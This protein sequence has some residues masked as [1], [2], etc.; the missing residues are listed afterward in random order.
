[1]TVQLSAATPT[2]RARMPNARVHTVSAFTTTAQPTLTVGG[3]RL[4]TSVTHGEREGTRTTGR[5]ARLYY[6][7]S[8]VSNSRLVGEGSVHASDAHHCLG[9]RRNVWRSL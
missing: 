7:R 4:W 1:M 9:R 8:L 3:V 6:G 2:M 5:F